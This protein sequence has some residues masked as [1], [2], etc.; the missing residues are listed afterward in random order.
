MNTL[1]SNRPDPPATLRTDRLLLRPWRE[2]DRPPFAAMNT[3]AEVMRHF[4]ATLSR[5]QSDSLADRIQLHF[6][7]HGFGLWAVEVIGGDPFI[8]FTGLSIPEYETPFTPCVE[9]GWRIARPHWGRGYA[10]EAARATV[11]YGFE[12]LALNEIVSFT[13]PEN[14]PS[15]RVMEKLGMHRDP[16]GD[17]DHPRLPEAHPLRRHVLYRL[18]PRDVHPRT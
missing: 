3:D 8:G 5:E 11:A 16:A 13:V 9:I 18:K 14:A 2:A 15:R 12:A 7:R 6:D 10:P 1:P 4:A 17:F